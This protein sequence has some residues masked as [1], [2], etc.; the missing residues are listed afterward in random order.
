MKHQQPLRGFTLIEM[1]ITV[2]I[3]AI[4]AAIALPSYKEYIARGRRAEAQTILLASQQ[5]MERFYSENYSYEKNSAGSDVSCRSS[6]NNCPFDL[7]FTTSPPPGQGTALYDITVAATQS[8]YTITAK[9]KAGA[10][11]GADRC[12]DMTVD[13]LGRRSI[14]DKTYTAASL[15]AAITDCWK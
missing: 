9:R 1:M 13:H 7:R 12:G 5:W 10:S 3:V 8:A 2:A 14:V 11:M 4:L 15:A 6:T